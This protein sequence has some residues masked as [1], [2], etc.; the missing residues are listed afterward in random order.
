MRVSVDQDRCNGN[1]VCVSI[2]ADVFDLGEDGKAYVLVDE[3][4][5]DD[6]ER[7]NQ[8]VSMCPTQA[9]ALTYD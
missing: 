9:I 6:Q 5:S 8:A 2:A 4:A 3:V 1:G 7:M